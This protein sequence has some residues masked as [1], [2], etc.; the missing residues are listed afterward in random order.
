MTACATR[1]ATTWC[2]S[3][4]ARGRVCILFVH[5][6]QVLAGSTDISVETPEGVRCEADEADYILASVREVFPGIS[7]APEE[8]V[9]RFAGVR[10]LPRSNAGVNAEISRDQQ[11]DWLPEQ[12]GVRR[13]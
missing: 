8:I 7:I 2:I 4:I 9:F 1:S 5:L 12:P 3:P 13:C 6:G 10:P 11:C